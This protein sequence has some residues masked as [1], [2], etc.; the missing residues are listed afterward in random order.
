[1]RMQFKTYWQKLT[2][3]ARAAFAKRVGTT[4]G[5]CR[6]LAYGDKRIELGLADAIVAAAQPDIALKDLPLTQRA[7]FQVEAR[8][9]D[10]KTERRAKCRKQAG[11]K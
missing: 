3:E 9:W 8:K 2:P 5:Y 10:G 7:E 6:Q 1:M 11:G 4:E